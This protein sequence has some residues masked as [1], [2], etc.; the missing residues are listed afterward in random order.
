M[1]RSRL[2]V[3]EKVTSISRSLVRPVFMTNIGSK[4]G[5][6]TD[7][8]ALG[9]DR[10]LFL[11]Q[12]LDFGDIFL[13]HRG[14][15]IFNLRYSILNPNRDIDSGSKR[16]HCQPARTSDEDNQTFLPSRLAS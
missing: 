3:L 9:Q 11:E 5:K 2:G 14:S 15:T 8:I 12:A 1:N 4:K 16:N 6:R 13:W 7:A 10:Q